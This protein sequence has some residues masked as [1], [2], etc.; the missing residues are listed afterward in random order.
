VSLLWGAQRRLGRRGYIDLNA[1]PQLILQNRPG[2]YTHLLVPLYQNP[3]R[4]SLSF[5]FNATVGLGW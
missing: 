5:Q 3:N 2:P 4:P 1:G